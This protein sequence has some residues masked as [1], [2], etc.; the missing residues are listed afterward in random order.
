MELDTLLE[1]A[2]SRADEGDWQAAAEL[3]REHREEFDE[4]AAYH[5]WLGVAERELGHEGVAYEHFRRA[6]ALQPQDP[7]VLA[8]VGNG[9]AAFD[10]PDAM[11]ALKTAAITAP[12][13]PLTRLLYGAYLSREGFHD[14]AI[15]Q[16]TAAR[17]L[18]ETDPQIAYELG[19]AHA[20]AGDHE[21][22]SVALADAVALDPED[23]W[24][25]VV[26]G[27]VLLE[28]DRLE[29][30]V[31]ELLEGATLR[32]EDVEAQLLASLAAAAYGW[33]DEAYEMLERARIRSA[34]GDWPLVAAVEEQVNAGADE[35]RTLLRE[36]VG[37]QAL[38]TRLAERP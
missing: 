36:D 10:D 21:R 15:E 14:W 30:A 17:E 37:P 19:V 26:F 33:L 11:E 38:R 29:E 2:L 4:D 3:L 18:D 24:A 8:T 32:P 23:G 34:E 5:C 9:I 6:L 27:L 35:A 28:L 20:L 31:G 25:R 7:Y 1:R 12:E 22:A 13:M 16:L